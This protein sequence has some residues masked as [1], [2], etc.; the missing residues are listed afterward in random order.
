MKFLFLAVIIYILAQGLEI[1]HAY[2]SHP[3]AGDT[4]VNFW[5]G[6]TLIISANAGKFLQHN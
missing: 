2:G 6:D 4:Y 5:L 3:H 1:R